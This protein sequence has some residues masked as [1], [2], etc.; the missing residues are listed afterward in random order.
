MILSYWCYNYAKKISLINIYGPSDR[1]SP[2]FI[3]EIYKA[4]NE[5]QNVNIIIGG[6]W[7]CILNMNIDSGNYTS[8][9]NR[10]QTRVK[11]KDL[12]TENNLIDIFRELHPDKR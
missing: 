1:D 12:M 6:D 9:V 5:F 11:I 7:N 10:P 3:D 4:L 2:E 8:T